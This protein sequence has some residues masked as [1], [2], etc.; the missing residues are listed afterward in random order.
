M[1]L[2]NGESVNLNSELE[3]SGKKRIQYIHPYSWSPNSETLALAY[4]N[5][6]SN[7]ALYSTDNKQYSFTTTD[8]KYISTA[9][10]LWKKNGDSL[11]IVSEQPSDVFK[12]YRLDIQNQTVKEIAPISRD[13]LSSLK[14]YGP[15]IIDK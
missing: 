8:T 3:L 2:N 15:T 10:L 14:D 9:F 5:P 12:L 1:N 4:E 13:E 11:D 7:I 6:S